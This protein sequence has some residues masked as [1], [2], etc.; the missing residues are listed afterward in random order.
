MPAKISDAIRDEAMALAEETGEPQ[1]LFPCYDGLATLYLD[2]DE[3]EQAEHYMRKAKETCERAGVDLDD[4]VCG[5]GRSRVRELPGFGLPGQ[6]LELVPHILGRLVTPVGIFLQA[7]PDDPVEERA[8]DILRN[9]GIVVAAGHDHVL[10]ERLCGRAVLLRDGA[11]EADGV[12]VIQ[13]DEPAFN[14][15]MGEVTD[16]GIA[17]LERLEETVLPASA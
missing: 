13:F 9:G 4:D 3:P 6:I 11:L 14:V 7:V 17:A 10:L 12:D 2:L 5:L 8:H 1:L 16:W 15:F